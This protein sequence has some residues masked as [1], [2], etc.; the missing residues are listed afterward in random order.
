MAEKNTRKRKDNLR[1]LTI[2]SV[3]LALSVVLSFLKVWEMP[4]GGSVTLLSMLPVCLVSKKYGVSG[5]L[6]TAFLFSVI[7][8]VQGFASGNV[9]VYCTTASTW[10]ICMLFD[11]IV[12]FTVL[13][14]SGAFRNKLTA[15]RIFKYEFRYF[16]FILGIIMVM[17]LRFVCHYVTGV[18]IWGQWAEGMSPYLYSFLY[19]GQYMLPECIFTCIGA[20]LLMK[21]PQLHKLLDE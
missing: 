19:N 12:P 10:I 11:Y 5:A 16:G 20:V 15:V 14:F 7:Q 3:M 1:K 6:P 8:F 2:C 9:F 21:V 4:M 18:V 17:L 13:G